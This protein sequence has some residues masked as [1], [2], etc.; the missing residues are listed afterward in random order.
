[1]A[2]PAPPPPVA[3]P[4]LESLGLSVERP[5]VTIDVDEALGLRVAGLGD[6]GAGN[7]Y[8][9]R[10]ER[11]AL[12]QNIFPPGSPD[13]IDLTEGRRLFD[14]YFR[15]DCHAMEPAPGAVAALRR[16]EPHAGLLILS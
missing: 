13:H 11:F 9:M 1:M 6:S 4:S 2:E 5:R 14:E 8:E 15:T 10:V 7:G 16:L 3:A 12:F